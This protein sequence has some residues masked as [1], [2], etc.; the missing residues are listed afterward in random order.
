MR[1]KTAQITLTFICLLVGVMLVTQFRTQG[2]IQR[3]VLA[4]PAANQALLISNLYD[5]NVSLRKELEDLTNQL[6]KFDRSSDPSNVVAMGEEVRRLQTVTGLTEVS[7]PGIELRVVAPLA[8]EDL[9]DLV[10]ELRNAG[11]E[12]L[13]LGSQRIVAR[14]AIVSGRGGIY[15][16][17]HPAAQPF[18]FEAVGQ[19][20]TIEGALLRKG[21]VLAILEN[22][23]ADGSF[24]VVK[25]DKIMLPVY[26]Q[27]YRWS[28]ARVADK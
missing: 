4:E 27:G 13:A 5:S 24:R 26:D 25:R 18:V 7:G 11:A 2:K 16:N 22:A 9:R 14:S 15:V 1:A 17:G 21:G 28:S 23:Y 3:S 6:D 10:N 19:P 8:A 12:A 20:E